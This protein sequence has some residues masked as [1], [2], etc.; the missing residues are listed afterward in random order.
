VCRIAHR[1][2]RCLIFAA[3]TVFVTRLTVTCS[4]D[5]VESFVALAYI[6]SYFKSSVLLTHDALINVF[7]VTSLAST[8]ARFADLLN[9]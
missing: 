7:P 2:R 3:L 4:S 9:S 6:G 8:V 1:T 5:H